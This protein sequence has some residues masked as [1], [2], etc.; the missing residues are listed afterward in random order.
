MEIFINIHAFLINLSGSTRVCQSACAT[1]RVSQARS[2]N[3]SSLALCQERRVVNP[4]L[5]P[6]SREMLCQSPC[7][8]LIERD[9]M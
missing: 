1:I 6:T 5:A 4:P 9:V 7:G 2:L 8:I 3:Q